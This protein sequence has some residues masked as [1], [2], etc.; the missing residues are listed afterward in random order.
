M[1]VEKK[2]EESFG[3]VCR[4]NWRNIDITCLFHTSLWRMLTNVYS[5]V[6]SLTRVL[7]ECYIS[8]ILTLCSRLWTHPLCILPVLGRNWV[9]TICNIL[10][11]NARSCIVSRPFLNPN[12]LIHWCWLSLYYPVQCHRL[13]GW[14]SLLLLF[15]VNC[16]CLRTSL[17]CS[18]E[19]PLIFKDW[20]Y[21]LLQDISARN[22]A[23]HF[24]AVQ[25]NYWGHYKDPN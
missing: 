20:V 19:T 8:R 25:T 10:Y 21:Y 4:F 22:G 2:I 23:S 6:S 7:F 13:I 14:M 3:R 9:I 17:P 11:L 12:K 1:S 5:G 16:R 15:S 18:H 24:S